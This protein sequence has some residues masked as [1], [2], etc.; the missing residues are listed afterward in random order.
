MAGMGVQACDLPR[1]PQWQSELPRCYRP[2]SAKERKN[3]RLWR[4]VQFLCRIAL[5]KEGGSDAQ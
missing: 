3:A 2:P 5:A 1:A 4:E